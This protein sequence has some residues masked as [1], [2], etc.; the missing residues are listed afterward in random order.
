MYYT[1]LK[2]KNADHIIQNENAKQ[3]TYYTKLKYNIKKYIIN[4]IKMQNY[5]IHNIQN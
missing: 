4:K 2:H 5:K 3:R 1:K